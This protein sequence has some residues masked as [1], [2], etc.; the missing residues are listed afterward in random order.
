MLK[1]T[2]PVKLLLGEYVTTG[3]KLSVVFLVFIGL[4]LELSLILLC[5]LTKTVP[6][7]VS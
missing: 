6:K 3:V 5:K 4:K 7:F 2:A 1:T